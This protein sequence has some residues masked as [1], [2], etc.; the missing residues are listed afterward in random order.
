MYANELAPAISKPEAWP[1]DGG[2]G[3][4]STMGGTDCSLMVYRAASRRED[5]AVVAVGAVGPSGGVGAM[6]QVTSGKWGVAWAAQCIRYAYP[7]ASRLAHSPFTSLHR[8]G[9]TQPLSGPLAW[10]ARSACT[11]QW[12]RVLWPQ[13]RWWHHCLWSWWQQVQAVGRTGL[14]CQA[15]VQAVSCS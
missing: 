14:N 4:G 9:K 6:G 12:A 7:H 15:W 11:E 3:G 10:P 13:G 1:G 2:G 5:S 8:F